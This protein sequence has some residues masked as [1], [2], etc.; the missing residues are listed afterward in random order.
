MTRPT[1]SVLPLLSIF[2]LSGGA[3]LI[4]EVAWARSLGQAM[5]HSLQAMT[6]V[7]VVFLLGLAFG[8]AAGGRWSARWRSPLRAY[9]ALELTIALLGLFSPLT[10][11]MV[12]W[13]IERFGPALADGLPLAGLRLVLAI[14]VLA[15]PTLAMGATLPCLVRQVERSVAAPERA[16]G[17]LYGCNTLGAAAGAALGSFLLL[18]LA[19]TRG[20]ILF[21][22]L[23]NLLAGW[24]AWRLGRGTAAGAAESP[25]PTGPGDVRERARAGPGALG[26]PAGEPERSGDVEAAAL[27]GPPVWL[28]LLVATLSGALGAIFQ[29]S[30]VRIIALTFG[31]SVYALGLT[32]TAYI[33][34]LGIGPLIAARGDLVRRWLSAQRAAAALWLVGVLSLAL[35]PAFGLLPS[36]AAA[37][38]TRLAAWPLVLV[39]AQFVCLALLLSPATMAQGAAFPPLAI[40]AGDRRRSAAGAVGRAFAASSGGSA[41]GFLLAGFVAIPSLGTR[42]TLAA[43][44]ATALVAAPLLL[45]RGR[46]VRPGAAV[47]LRRRIRVVAT[48]VVLL[49]G[50]LLILL[51]PSWDRQQMSGGAFLYGPVYTAALGRHGIEEAIRRRGEVLYYR[52]D[53]AGVV[54]VR[55]NPQGVL[56]LQIN[57]KTEASGGGDMATQLLTAHLP[58]LLHPAPHDLLLVGLASGVSLGAALKHPLASARVVEIVPSVIG[59]ARL[60]ERDNHAAL[61]DPRV[62]VVIDDARSHLMARPGTYD[63]IASQPSNP[64]VS[65]VANLFTVDF[66][67]LAQRRLRPGGLFMQWVQAYRLELRDLRGVVR[68]FL[69]VFPA[70]T[71][72]EE[73]AGGGDYFLVGG[74]A[75]IAVDPQRWRTVPAGVWTDLQRAGIAGAADLLSRFV[76]G[77]DGLR[78][79]AAG[80]PLHTDDDLYLEWRAP[81]ALFRDTLAAQISGMNRYREPVNPLLPEGYAERDPALLAALGERLRQRSGRLAIAASLKHADRMA[82]V[83]PHLAAGIDRL[84]S[85]RYGEAVLALSAAAGEHPDSANAH[86][87]LGE[88]Y[89]GAGLCRPAIVA[90]RQALRCDTDMAAAWN[91]LG[92]CL[93]QEGEYDSA[94]RALGEAV[95]FDPANPVARNNLGTA[96]LRDGDLDGAERLFRDALAADPTLAAAHANLGLVLR[97]RGDLAGAIERYRAA[98]DLDPL[99]LDAR[100]NLAAGLEEQG[101]TGAAATALRW[102]LEVNPADR[103]AGA[104]LQ[105][106]EGEA[107]GGH[108]R[109]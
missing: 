76:C 58:L 22:A 40:L 104:L 6:A 74:D 99:N 103:D 11:R 8:A 60:F 55:R 30:W 98:L 92:I 86:L 46:S 31:S 61:D 4:Y 19:G 21:A 25:I 41:L 44:A 12:P 80:A 88:A 43:T 101:D 15:P 47:S 37:L 13:A 17:W 23:L 64:W 94:D 29:V 35:L 24:L 85:G 75:P 87:L 90:Y 50:P 27:S 32:L 57:G 20:T 109:P 53:G 42:R 28:V 49:F 78:A 82:L 66:Y 67:R 1:S 108:R 71:L 96:L 38:S 107:S 77:P 69:E 100:Y 81:L 54:T 39:G 9:A 2:A 59:A 79:F 16:I 26:V 33:L 97:R 52:E 65:G 10:L 83:D 7:L 68:S 105:S 95:R 106:I 73:S 48:G 3:G 51:L 5:G 102:I 56:S 18:P 45:L 91:G 89:R 63:V 14:V 36:I 72:W 84:R 34:G 62:R 70:A 93:L